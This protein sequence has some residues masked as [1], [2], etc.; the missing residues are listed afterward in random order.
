MSVRDHVAINFSNILRL[1]TPLLAAICGVL[2][3]SA[4]TN[5]IQSD[6]VTEYSSALTLDGD[7]PAVVTRTLQP[8][9]Y[10]I[11]A[12]E[13]EI[14]ARLTV[15]VDGTAAELA[16]RV[17]RH[18]TIY[19]VVSVTG[20]GKLHLQLRSTDHRSKQGRGDQEDLEGRCNTLSSSCGFSRGE[21][22]PGG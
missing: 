13:H 14:D 5:G 6:L 3:T 19:K 2:C 22:D 7:S 18:G 12:R 21:E 20:P 15:T 11:E 8:G 1:R 4:C 17:P 16:D 10:L 9:D